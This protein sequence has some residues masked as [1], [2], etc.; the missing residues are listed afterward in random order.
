MNI[1]CIGALN[2]DRK[3]RLA[4]ALQPGTSNPAQLLAGNAGGVA[5]NVA[6]HLARLGAGAAQRSRVRLVSAWGDDPEGQ[7]LQQAAQQAGVELLGLCRDGQASGQYTAVLQPDGDLALALADM[8]VLQQLPETFW[9]LAESTVRRSDAVAID[10]NLPTAGVQR[11][12]VAARGGG[13]PLALVAVSAPK[14]AHLPT[15][16]RGVD[17]L[18][19]NRDELAAVAQHSA[20]PN[21]DVVTVWSHLQARGLRALLLTQGAD[22]ATLCL[23]DGLHHQAAPQRVDA[24]DVTGA[25]DALSAT[26]LHAWWLQGL[27]LADAL[28]QGQRAAASVLLS[29]DNA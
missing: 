25:G 16:L 9:A 19:L 27:P 28:S 11:L 21:G 8:Q 15:D 29:L 6:R 24:L 14:M 13:T 1:A 22:G 26:L 2:W 7:S 20:L 4:Q 12:C 10:L 5:F 3:L 23:P 18:L 17:L